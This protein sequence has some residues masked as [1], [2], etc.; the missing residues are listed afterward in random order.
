MT[1]AGLLQHVL[2]DNECTRQ[3]RGCSPE[4]VSAIAGGVAA[5]STG[6]SWLRRDAKG[7]Q[8]RIGVDDSDR[9]MSRCWLFRPAA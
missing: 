7:Y 5:V 2:D 6:F 8:C 4:W 9:S 3:R 1:W